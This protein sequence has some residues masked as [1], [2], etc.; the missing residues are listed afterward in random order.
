VTTFWTDNLAA[1]YWPWLPGDEDTPGLAEDDGS[2]DDDPVAAVLAPLSVIAL[3]WVSTHGKG[4][5]PGRLVAWGSMLVVV[6]VLV[7]VKAPAAAGAVVS[8]W[9]NGI[10]TAIT[11]LGHFLTDV[12]S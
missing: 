3:W 5:A 12:F 4:T 10:S 7:A 9:F 6:L 8:G 11:G 1:L 2:G